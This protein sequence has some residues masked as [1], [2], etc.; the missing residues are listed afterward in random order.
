MRYPIPI[1]VVMPCYNEDKYVSLAIKSILQQTFQH[2]EFIIINDGSTDKSHNEIKSFSDKRIHYINMRTNSGN[3]PARNIGMKIAK[4]KYICVMDADDIAFPDRLIIQYKYLE[5]HLYIAGIGSCGELI[6]EEGRLINPKLTRPTVSCAQFKTFLLLDNLVLHPSLMFRASI[7][8]NHHLFYNEQYIYS[9]DFDFVVRCASLF[10]LC[11]IENILI[12]Y[13][14]HEGQI[15]TKYNTFL[16]K[17]ADQIRLEQLK[18]FNLP[19][20]E[21]EVKIY[22][23]IM[24]RKEL[25]ECHQIEEGMDIL[26][27]ILSRN[28]VL[29]LYNQRF[30]HSLFDYLLSIAREKLTII[31]RY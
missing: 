5:R 13:R 25:E 19:F 4:G 16:T 6:D 18:K 20:S 3:Y 21:H 7:L 22:L 24:K 26:N 15:T 30:L 8:K 1:S 27:K 9:S 12:K 28:A 11:N 23:A 29:K 2:F 17:E 10:P 14:L 31:A